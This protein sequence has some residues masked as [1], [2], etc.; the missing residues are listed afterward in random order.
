MAKYNNLSDY[1][2]QKK[3]EE[4][5]RECIRLNKKVYWV[6]KQVG[7]PKSTYYG[8]LKSGC[9]SKS[10]APKTVWN[11][12]PLWLENEIIK[13]RDDIDLYRSQ[14]SPL[15]ISV[16]LEEHNI[17]ITKTGVWRVLVR[18]GRNRLFSE[19][20]KVFIIYPKSQEFLEVVCIDDIG[21][22]NNKPRELSIFNAID[23]FSQELVGITFVTHRINRYDVIELL[24]QIKT[25]H[26][27][28]PK[29]VRLDNAKAH[30]STMV[31]E[32]CRINNIKL[33]FI[34]KGTPQQ[35][36]PVEAFNGVIQTDLLNSRLWGGWHDLSDKQTVLEDYLIYYNNKKPLN[37]DPLKRTPREISLGTTLVTTQQRLKIKLLRKYYGQ[38]VARKATLPNINNPVLN[39]TPV[40]SEMCVS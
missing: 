19:P 6:L 15:G 10:K 26:S 13:I 38:V 36:W 35:N 11:K 31:K 2:K 34:D 16:K 27:R 20:K 25:R 4:I 18:H 37:S 14:R 7:I 33:Q 9:K 12:T 22:T 17:F 21:I 29:I 5:K 30:V 32:F 3:V 1:E 28:Y 23:E 39:A 8:W 40:L 24:E